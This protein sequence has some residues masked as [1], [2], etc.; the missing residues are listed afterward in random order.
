V[1]GKPLSVTF[2]QPDVYYDIHPELLDTWGG[3]PFLAIKTVGFFVRVVLPIK[4]TD[5][6]AVDFGTWL[7][8]SDESFRTAWLN[9]NTPEYKDLV[10]EGYL[11]NA[12]APW[13]EFPHSMV[14]AT[15]RDPNEVPV[16]TSAS[17]GDIMALM[18]MEWPH[19]RVLAPYVD[20]LRSQP[21]PADAA[22]AE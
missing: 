5:D 2:E 4:C 17:H 16:V 10:L 15:V 19:A 6:F 3:D 1:G 8:V 20:V 14:T 7:E 11:A 21:L 13:P 18:R 22:P 12:V 9:W